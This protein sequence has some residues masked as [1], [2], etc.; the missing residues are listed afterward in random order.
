MQKESQI[1]QEAINSIRNEISNHQALMND[2]LKTA[3]N[4]KIIGIPTALLSIVLF[5]KFG[6]LYGFICLFAA[7]L[8]LRKYNRSIGMADVHDSV[9]NFHRMMLESEITGNKEKI[10]WFLK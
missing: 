2:Y 5:V 10:P 3:K 7:F 8:C 4:M 6:M 1:N 9:T